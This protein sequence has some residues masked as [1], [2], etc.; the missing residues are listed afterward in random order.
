M[1]T[2]SSSVCVFDMSYY[3]YSAAETAEGRKRA[4]VNRLLFLRKIPRQVN[5]YNFDLSDTFT[6]W[7]VNL[8]TKRPR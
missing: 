4:S 5:D 2:S 7:F 3:Y 6:T 8:N 1:N